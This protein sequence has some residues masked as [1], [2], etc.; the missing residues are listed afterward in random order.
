MDNKPLIYTA[1]SSAM[2]DVDA[3]GKDRRNQQQG[4]SFR[5]IDDVYNSLHAVM[6][7]H[8]IFSTSE[9][10]SIS[11]TEKP[12]KTGGTLFYEKYTITYTFHTVD[13]SNVKT[14]VVGIAMDSG[15]KAGN[16]AMAIAHKY[17]L[18][19]LFCI[20]T[21]D[22]KDPD[23]ET[24]AVVQMEPGED[25]DEPPYTPPPAHNKITEAQRRGLFAAAKDAGK[26]TEQMK[27]IV[28]GYGYL[29][30]KDIYR[31]DYDTILKTIGAK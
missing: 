25:R 19:Q 28:E 29:S 1:I 21:E 15:D 24:H 2:A 8:K 14:T 9:I 6:V 31:H 16:K 17:A 18:L 12:T 20:P 27:K 4:F 23:A 26:T 5:G 13:G 3:I 7:K 11:S 22:A 10:V 30:S